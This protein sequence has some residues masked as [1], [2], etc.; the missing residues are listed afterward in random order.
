[1]LRLHA[2]ITAAFLL[3]TLAGSGTA[4]EFKRSASRKVLAPPDIVTHLAIAMGG[5]VS[6][7]AFEAGIL[8]EFTQQLSLYNR[9]S[10]A[11]GRDHRY[12]V[13]VLAGASA[14]SMSLAVL[15]NEMYEPSHDV[16]DSAYTSQSVFYRA[17]VEGIDVRGL[18]DPSR[19]SKKLNA[20]PFLFNVRD[21][22]SIANVAL[23]TGLP[24]ASD[25]VA[26]RGGKRLAPGLENEQPSDPPGRRG[27]RRLSIAPRR[28]GLGMTLSNMDGVTRKI[29]FEGATYEHT[30]F[31]DRR[32][33]L[34]SHDGR[35]ISLLDAPDV[36]ISWNDVAKTAIASGAFPFAFPPVTLER[37]RGEYMHAP[38]EFRNTKTRTFRY[39]DGGFFDNDPLQLARILARSLDGSRAN[40]ATADPL[41]SERQ[42]ALHEPQRDRRFIYL[43]PNVPVADPELEGEPVA[44]VEDRPW[45]DRLQSYASRIVQMGMGA[46][47][48]QGFRDYISE[49]DRNQEEI[50]ELAREVYALR[51]SVGVAENLLRAIDYMSTFDVASGD[52]MLLHKM[53]GY[54]GRSISG[55][56]VV[57]W[58]NLDVEVSRRVDLSQDWVDDLAIAYWLHGV[59]DSSGV[60][61]GS[62]GRILKQLFVQL[63]EIRGLFA[64]NNFVLITTSDEQGVV[65]G[66]FNAF[67]GFFNHDLRDLDFYLGRYCA[68]QVLMHDLGVDVMAAFQ[69]TI[70]V[71]ELDERRAPLRNV[72]SLVSHFPTVEDRM[73]FRNDAER[74]LGAYVDHLEL[75]RLPG[76]AAFSAGNRWL[77]SSIFHEPR[78]YLL[79]GMIGYDK[80]H[81]LGVGGAADIRKMLRWVPILRDTR[82]AA[83]DQDYDQVFR[84]ADRVWGQLFVAGEYGFWDPDGVHYFDVGGAFQLHW[85]AS[86]WVA[87]RFMFEGGRRI[88]SERITDLDGSHGTFEAIGIE[89]GIFHLGVRTER[90]P[91]FLDSS[92]TGLMRVGFSLVPRTTWKVL[93]TY[94]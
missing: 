86:N 46:A 55:R 31:D 21:I 48:G 62:A 59:S 65:G 8:A 28:L 40:D 52:V 50:V 81:S 35:D 64:T 11:D 5:A 15:A 16:A 6:L 49:S 33:F 78:H 73:A 87:P 80:L 41:D 2:W 32:T 76:A 7:G 70:S 34:L 79:R 63:F 83:R 29:E 61:H 54:A 4:G 91:S 17:W 1:M 60:E 85:R 88:R 57:Y 18:I 37:H 20:D 90:S 23:G 26:V 14:G 68:Q 56:P 67:G 94:R 75:G 36:K 89:L 51:D 22:Y 77:D 43:A 24:L 13:D 10:E 3:M 84:N 25:S 27:E 69:D 74:R 58:R 45:D 44:T 66:R 9:Q 93:R 47:G 71:G 82:I 30:Y 39:V 38:L 12:V 53:V 19:G 72:K 42:K 92:P